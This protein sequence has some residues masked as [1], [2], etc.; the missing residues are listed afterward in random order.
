VH[1]LA[2]TR[3]EGSHNVFMH[4]EFPS[5]GC[6]DVLPNRLNHT[7]ASPRLLLS[8]SLEYYI[9]VPSITLC[10]VL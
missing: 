2:N 6:D 5:R 10:F 8:P 1:D 7:D 3:L 9:V 4:E